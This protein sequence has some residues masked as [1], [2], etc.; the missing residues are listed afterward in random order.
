MCSLFY[1]GDCAL[2]FG[3]T[4]SGSAGLEEGSGCLTGGRAHCHFRIKDLYDLRF[5]A[6]GLVREIKKVELTGL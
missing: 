4:R 6:M 2:G 1:I 3:N 5:K